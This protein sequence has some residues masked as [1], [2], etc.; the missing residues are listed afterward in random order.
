MFQKEVRT[1][2]EATD[3]PAAPRGHPTSIDHE[4]DSGHTRGLVACQKQ[5]KNGDVAQ[6]ARHSI[7]VRYFEQ[8][9]LIR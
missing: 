1:H 6:A 8:V 5:R 9:K 4:I 2:A 7:G 3:L